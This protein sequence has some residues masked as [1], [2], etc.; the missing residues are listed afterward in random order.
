MKFSSPVLLGI[1]TLLQL[2]SQLTNLD[3]FVKITPDLASSLYN[4][5]RTKLG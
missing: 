2:K 3:F 5:S 4:R 1:L